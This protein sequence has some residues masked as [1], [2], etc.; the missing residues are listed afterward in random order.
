MTIKAFLSYSTRDKELAGELRELLATASIDLFLAHQTL[1]P[2]AE[3]RQEIKKQISSREI[4]ILLLTKNFHGSKWTDQ[5]VGMAIAQR[6]TILPL[7]YPEPPYGFVSDYHAIRVTDL[8]RTLCDV[9]RGILSQYPKER[10]PVRRRFVSAL[11]KSTTFHAALS[12]LLVLQHNFF[13]LTRKEK[14]KILEASK[15]NNQIG[16]FKEV[17]RFI[18]QL[19][20][21]LES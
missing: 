5:E 15:K 16:G 2:S 3:W 18:L 17:T 11:C 9:I 14:A 6:K 12:S 4:F 19:K 10:S 1:A 20:K 21:E 13:P 7:Q 8:G